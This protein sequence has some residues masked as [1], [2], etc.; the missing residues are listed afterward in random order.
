MPGSLISL[1]GSNR[2]FRAQY[3]DFATVVLGELRNVHR[4]HLAILVTAGASMETAERIDD[5]FCEGAL[6]PDEV[7]E[8]DQCR[9]PANGANCAALLATGFRWTSE[10]ARA[11]KEYRI[12]ATVVGQIRE[13][14][15]KLHRER[16]GL[17]QRW[18][19]AK[20]GDSEQRQMVEESLAQ[21]EEKVRGLV[22]WQDPAAKEYEVPPEDIVVSP[23]AEAEKAWKL[24][25][26][27]KS[28]WRV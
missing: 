18:L 11:A 8:Y 9:L 23:R 10:A 27:W 12:S 21:L 6:Y 2:F 3:G 7:V 24:W 16:E 17:L 26:L 28:P 25:R 19:G 14:I 13:A 20:D 15:E 1:C 22:N 4:L 5:P